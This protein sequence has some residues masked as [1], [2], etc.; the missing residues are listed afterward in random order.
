MSVAIVTGSA[1]LVGAEA[2]R[3][4]ASLGMDVVGVDI[5]M[6]R[7]FFGPEAS[8]RWQ[9]IELQRDLG[10]R[11]RH[12]DAD[13]RDGDA[14]ERLFRQFG[15]A[16]DVVI[17]TAAQ[18]SHDWAAT[19][20]LMDFSVNADGTLTVL[21]AMR[22]HAPHAAFIFTSS[23]KV[24]G[25]RPNDLPLVELPTRWEIAADHR[26]A[27]G[28]LEDMPID[29]TLHSVFGAS[30]VAAD[31]L[32]QEYG[33]YYGLNAVCFRAGCI[34]GPGHSGTELH[35]FLAYLVKCAATGTRYTVFGYGGKQVRDNIHAADLVSAFERFVREPRAGEVYNIGGGRASHCSMQEAIGICE[36]LVGQPLDWT[37]SPVARRGD[38]MWWISG[39]TKFQRD[40][41]GWK[42]TRSVPD[43]CR[44]IYE[45]NVERWGHAPV[46]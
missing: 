30:K 15:P 17:H 11:Y 40:Y 37:Y 23:N 20:P 36:R 43:I 1:G 4:F 39:L 35:G 6:R 3:R 12:Y 25:D 7:V 27:D 2:S 16:T 32:V 14:M 28:V 33:R 21:D 29:G 45:A 38:H 5:D 42:P 19:R 8:T 13:V 9:V 44:E 24:Y 10:Q 26:Y 18:P 41:P 34:T 31:V 46:A 22:R